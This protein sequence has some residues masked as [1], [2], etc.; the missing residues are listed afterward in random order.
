LKKAHEIRYLLAVIYSPDVPSMTLTSASTIDLRSLMIRLLGGLIIFGLVCIEY[1][2]PSL[3]LFICY[4]KPPHFECTDLCI[5]NVVDFQ[6]GS[7]GYA[8]NMLIGFAHGLGAKPGLNARGNDG[9]RIALPD[10]SGRDF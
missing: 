10:F 2:D 8:G 1:A 6:Y 4:L 9:D 3:V 5:Q 7:L